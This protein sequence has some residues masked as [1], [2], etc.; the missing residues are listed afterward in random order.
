MATESEATEMNTSTKRIRRSKGNDTASEKGAS[1]T[2]Y[3]GFRLPEEE[4]QAIEEAARATGESVSEYVRKAIAQRREGQVHVVPEASI[5]Y[6]IPFMK[7]TDNQSSVT[8]GTL[9]FAKLQFTTDESS[10]KSA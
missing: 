3:L 4:Y 5:T 8:E 6:G 9:T 2:A 1:K 10:Q 7:V